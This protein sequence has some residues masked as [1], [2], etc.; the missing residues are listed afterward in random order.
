M[1][2]IHRIIAYGHSRAI[3]R[4]GSIG[5]R[6]TK[7]VDRKCHLATE[8]TALAIIRNEREMVGGGI[9]VGKLQRVGTQL[10]LHVIDEA[11]GLL[12]RRL[13]QGLTLGRSVAHIVQIIVVAMDGPVDA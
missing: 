11:K 2:L 12:L 13:F 3:E 1:V 4:T 9:D 7:I 8:A 6:M 5:I 10:M